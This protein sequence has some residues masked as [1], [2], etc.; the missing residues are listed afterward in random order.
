[1]T[2]TTF[3]ELFFLS[4]SLALYSTQLL[5][6]PPLFFGKEAP[7][8]TPEAP[9]EIDPDVLYRAHQI[10][11]RLGLLELMS[12]PLHLYKAEASSK[13]EV[14]VEATGSAA[15]VVAA[16]E[17]VVFAVMLAERSWYL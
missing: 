1:M 8:V 6:V 14:E 5:H 13:H 4:D 16:V 2:H 7:N 10:F 11:M 15:S 3:G 17:S 9:L 12:A